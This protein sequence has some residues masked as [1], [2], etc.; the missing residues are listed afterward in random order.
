[1][2]ESVNPA[3]YPPDFSVTRKPAGGSVS[4]AVKRAAVQA[5]QHASTSP[6]PHPSTFAP[7]D[8]LLNQADARLKAA[9]TAAL[10][11]FTSA[12]GEAQQLLDTSNQMAAEAGAALEANAWASWSKYMAAA[13]DTRNGILTAAAKSYDQAVTYAHTRYQAALT[14]AAKTYATILTDVNTAKTAVTK[15]VA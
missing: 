4:P 5:A 3:A 6:A 2:A 1:M 13:D 11:Q 8:T 15:I 9:I 10:G 12:V 7:W 14:E